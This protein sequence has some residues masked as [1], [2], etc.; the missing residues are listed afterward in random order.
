MERITRRRRA[1]P[2]DGHAAQPRP[3]ARPASRRPRARGRPP[4]WE[5]VRQAIEGARALLPLLEARHADQL[6]PVRDT[7]ARLQMIYAQQAGGGDAPAAEGGAAAGGDAAASRGAS[8]SR[9]PEGPGPAQSSGPPLGPG[10]VAPFAPYQLDRLRDRS[11][12]GPYLRPPSFVCSLNA[13]QRGSLVRFPGRPRGRRRAG[14]RAARRGVRPGHE[15]RAPG[16]VARQR[17]HAR[18]VGGDPGGRVRV[19]PP[20]VHDDRDR[21]RRP[22]RRC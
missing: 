9:G 15:P 8:R 3:P 2:D 5:Q 10:P 6:G 13:F 12:G 21:R 19:P 11:G 18:P 1:D 7:L 16:P 14:L 20:P 4:D 22:L 17:G